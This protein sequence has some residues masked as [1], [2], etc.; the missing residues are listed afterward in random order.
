MYFSLF[1]MVHDGVLDRFRLSDTVVVCVFCF[2]DRSGRVGPEPKADPKYWTRTRPK[3][4][5]NPPKTLRVG[6][7]GSML[8]PSRIHDFE[9]FFCLFGVWMLRKC[10]KVK[11]NRLFFFWLSLISLVLRNWKQLKTDRIEPIEI[12]SRNGNGSSF[13]ISGPD[14]RAKTLGPDLARLLDEIFF[15]RARTCPS[16]ALRAPRASLGCGTSGPILWPNKKKMFA[17][18]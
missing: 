8:S 16:W 9:F 14:L 7:A 6:S 12:Q 3:H 4:P 2:K 10:G 15:S 5:F 13:S 18:Y 11:R 17:W 1:E